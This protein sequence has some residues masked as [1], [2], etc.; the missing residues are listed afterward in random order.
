MEHFSPYNIFD[1][2][3][4]VRRGQM[5]NEPSVKADGSDQFSNFWSFKRFSF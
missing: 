5:A 3:F 2:R 1:V 4:W